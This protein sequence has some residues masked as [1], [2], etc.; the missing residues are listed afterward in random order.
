MDKL[1]TGTAFGFYALAL[2][3]V[4]AH[5]VKLWLTREISYS[6]Y[7]YFLEVNPRGTVLTIC[8][9]LGAVISAVGAGQISNL[10]HFADVATAVLAGFACDS[11]ILPVNAKQKG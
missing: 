9:A 6:V 8:A 10:N 11:S 4:F 7:T 3:G 2:L 5:G 1:I